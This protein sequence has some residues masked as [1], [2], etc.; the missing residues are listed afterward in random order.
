MNVNFSNTAGRAHELVGQ[1]VGE[2]YTGQKPQDL[3]GC[4][5]EAASASVRFGVTIEAV[6][7]GA[8]ETTGRVRVNANF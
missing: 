5:A 6:D 8:G 2:A 3:T 4:V 7:S 1:F